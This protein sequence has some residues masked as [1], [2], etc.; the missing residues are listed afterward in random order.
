MIVAGRQAALCAANNAGWCDA[1]GRAHGL[2]GEFHPALWLNRAAMPPYY[3]NAVTLTP[4][5]TAAQLTAIG[6]LA[7]T[8]PALAVKDSFATLDLRPLG[9]DVL[10][11]ATWLWREADAPLPAGRALDWSAVAG[12]DGLAY[13][14]A[15]WAGRDAPPAGAER[16]FRPPLLAEP[17]VTF[18]AG[19]RGGR[20]VAVAVANQTGAVVGLS[21]V[22]T[23]DGDAAAVYAEAVAFAGRL[24]PG[25]ALVGYERGDDLAAALRA[26][27]APV[28][29]LRVWAR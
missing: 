28:G 8:Q 14:E 21:N 29:L 11:E 3:P 24:F 13:W 25:R 15:A 6:G 17:G 19:T 18:L 2:P 7:A 16:I 20:I 1:V 22:F 27:F 26:G 23:P 4:D 10:F 5:E 12:A 9:F